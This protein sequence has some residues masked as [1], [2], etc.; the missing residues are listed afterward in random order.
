MA[1]VLVVNADPNLKR[2]IK[3]ALPGMEHFVRH[4]AT[5]KTA[6]I[7]PL[8]SPPDLV[9][10]RLVADDDQ[11]P[12]ELVDLRQTFPTARVLVTAAL[13]DPALEGEKFQRVVRE[14][15]IEYCLIEPLDTAAIIQAIQTAL[16]LPRRS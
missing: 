5:L 3:L 6:Y 13:H 14:M 1:N 8:S 16:A 12:E 11:G 15:H 7:E 2:L 9:I 10:A 4:S